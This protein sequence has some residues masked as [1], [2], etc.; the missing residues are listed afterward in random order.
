MFHTNILEAQQTNPPLRALQ[1]ASFEDMPKNALARVDVDI[2]GTTVEIADA[3]IE[4]ASDRKC[5]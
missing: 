1:P 3:L 5:Q 2:V 4:L